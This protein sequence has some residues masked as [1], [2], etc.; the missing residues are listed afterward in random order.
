VTAGG[1]GAGAPR[2]PLDLFAAHLER[3]P[4]RPIFVDVDR[5]GRDHRSYTVAEFA[6][7]AGRVAGLLLRA[8]L[9]P[10]D[11]AVLVYP[12][13]SDFVVAFTACLMTGV[14][15]VAVYP[16]GPL[17]GGRGR[18]AFAAS[19]ADCGARVVLTSTAYDRSRRLGAA[20]GALTGET[21]AAPPLGWLRTDRLPSRTAPQVAWHRPAPDELALLQYTSGSTAHP[22]GVMITHQNLVEESA[23][24]LHDLRIGPDT[25]VVSWLP[26][27]HDFGLINVIVNTLC[28]NG[29][30]YL[31]SPT[32]F[33]RRPA[34]WFEA[35]S[36]V[37]ATIMVAPNF[38][39]EVAVR[40]TTEEQRRRWDLRSIAMVMSA[41]EPV[42]PATVDRF[43]T[44]FAVTGLR[45]EA[46]APAYGLAENC[47]A[48]S[49]NGRGA[50]RLDADALTEG[51]IVMGDGT[52]TPRRVAAYV[53]CGYPKT[54][55]HVR[56][57]DPETRKPCPP[58]RVGEIWVDA[59]TKALGYLGR[60]E[61][62][63]ETFQA[64]VAG[65][66]DGRRY[67]RT[68]DLG[69]LHE[70]QVY[71]T[72]RLKDIIV[73]RGRNHH[74]EDIEE[75]VRRCD[76]RIRPGGVVA[77]AVLPED[78]TSGTERLVVF[79][80]TRN[81]NE[82]DIT[83][84]AEVVQRAVRTVHQV[85]CSAVV[86]GEPGLVVKTTS[87]KVRRSACRELFLRGDIPHARL[88]HAGRGAGDPD[89][90]GAAPPGSAAHHLMRADRDPSAR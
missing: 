7:A 72:G 36:R 75:T 21:S 9:V 1:A 70:G 78:G 43:F 23:A 47:V 84:L 67:L 73:I 31:M 56:I 82:K 44:A 55:A 83:D 58:D 50:V 25:R 33:L 34:A 66:D 74:A 24:N 62:T 53:G 2:G 68:G 22:K 59:P 57:V 49:L 11:R 12:P 71:V 18:S 16:P 63:R 28:G 61:E 13:G 52:V 46:F 89:P 60:P 45:R 38:A 17:P 69:F 40:R 48:V 80:E 87:G 51:R 35:M 90:A 5:H 15:P 39:Y 14:V 79:A 29:T 41:A 42:V 27:F 19:V 64:R 32:D 65:A 3:Y 86:L 26:Q 37:A 6:A 81:R 20:V 88:V 76:P 4:D 10:G 85:A 77:F 54:G 30:V 8:G